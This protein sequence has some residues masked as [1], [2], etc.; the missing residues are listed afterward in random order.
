MDK[1]PV[2]KQ[3]D[4]ADKTKTKKRFE[5]V[6]PHRKPISSQTGIPPSQLRYIKA[7]R[8]QAGLVC[9]LAAWKS[10]ISALQDNP[11]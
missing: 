1:E 9:A 3:Q 6:H 4:F 10:L 7:S 5:G 8:L 2:G 11:H